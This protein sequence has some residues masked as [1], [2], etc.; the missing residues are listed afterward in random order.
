MPRTQHRE[1]GSDVS[2]ETNAEARGWANVLAGVPLFAELNRR[3]LNKVAALGRIRRFHDG[4]A[5]MRAGDPAT[6]STSSWRA[7]CR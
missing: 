2:K 4:T 5:I 3:H 7:R 6:R 1:A